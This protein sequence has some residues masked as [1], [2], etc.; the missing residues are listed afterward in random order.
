[1]GRSC[2][3]QTSDYF[4]VQRSVAILK[5]KEEIVPLFVKHFFDSTQFQNEL[6]KKARGVAQIGV[7]LNSLKKFEIPITTFNEQKRIVS[8]IESIFGR[9]DSTEKSLDAALSKIDLLKKSVL[10]RAFEGKLVP[11]DPND[12][13]ASALLERIK[14]EKTELEQDESVKRRKRNGK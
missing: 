8:K 10:K 6:K 9:I 3:V 5:L 7:Y 2:V 13:P 14:K 1:M 12:E 11:Q 4:T